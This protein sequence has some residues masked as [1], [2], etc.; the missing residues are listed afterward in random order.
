MCTMFAQARHTIFDVMK[1]LC[2]N[3]ARLKPPFKGTFQ[4]FNVVL[5]WHVARPVLVAGNFTGMFS[6]EMFQ[7]RF[8]HKERIPKKKADSLGV[9]LKF[10]L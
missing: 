5:N 2:S 9:P 7:T 6:V 3:H 10:E 1:F 4:I 8:K